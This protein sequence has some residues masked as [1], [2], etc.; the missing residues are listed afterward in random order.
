VVSTT[1][2]YTGGANPAPT[3]ETVCG[4]DGHTEAIQVEY[5]PGW[6]TYN[7]LL[8]HYY[9]GHTPSAG[10]PQYKS[11]I[12]YHDE[13]QRKQAEAVAESSGGIIDIEAAREWHDAED[14]HQKYYTKQGCSIQ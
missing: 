11:A 5:D 3:Y 14:Y 6:V 8:G 9:N 7:E 10:K 4:G 12:W 2:G 1:V 13:K